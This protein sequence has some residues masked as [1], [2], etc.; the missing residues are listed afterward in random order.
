MWDLARVGADHRHLAGHGLD[1]HQAEGL[2]P[3]RGHD[4]DGGA[5][6][7]SRI[8]WT[9]S[10]AGTY[11][12]LVEPYDEDNTAYCDAV[13]DLLILPVRAQVFLPLVMRDY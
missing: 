10:A 11:Y 3:A 5:G 6:L 9:P 13:Y 12:V 7:A 4:D 1:H 8:D 2:G